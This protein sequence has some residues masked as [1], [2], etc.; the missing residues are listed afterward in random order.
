MILKEVPS[1]ERPREKALCEGFDKLSNIELLALLIR[2]GTKD[3]NAIDIAKKIVYCLEDISSLSTMSITE[4]INFKGIGKSKAIEILAAVELGK[5][6]NINKEKT[7]SFANPQ[8][9][10]EYFKPR[11]NS[12]E[13][14]NLYVIYLDTRGKVT[15]IKH[16]SAGTHTQT[17]IDSKSIFKWAYKLNSSSMI[18]V[19]NHPSGDP[20]PSIA[21]YKITSEL[22]KQAKI[23]NFEIIDHVIIGNDY[24]S[25]KQHS[26][27]YKVF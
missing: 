18:L 19:H 17:L 16:I 5:R 15:S 25:M 4:L 26:K 12:V 8:S 11:F 20:T 1:C 13:Q 7:L 9:I 27:L 10:F 24:F 22:V 6:I 23:V 2:S 3:E 14:E 21:D